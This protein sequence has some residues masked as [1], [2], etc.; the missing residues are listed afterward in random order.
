MATTSVH[1]AP[2]K[3]GLSEMCGIVGLHL[4]DPQLYPDLGRLMVSM[5]DG[6]AERGPDSAGVAV[7]GDHRRVPEGHAAVSAFLGS[8]GSQTAVQLGA[9][10]IKGV[11]FCASNSLHFDLLTCAAAALE[12][13][14]VKPEQV[15]EVFFGNVLSAK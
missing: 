6:V 15:E 3:E 7:Y 12:R 2:T 14:Q 1:M 8:L 5:L 11:F 10:A 4:R 13:A 9:T